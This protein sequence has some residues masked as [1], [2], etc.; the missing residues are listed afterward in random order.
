MSMSSSTQHVWMGKKTRLHNRQFSWTAQKRNSSNN[1]K[2][3]Y[4]Q[5]LGCE[6][7]AQDITFRGNQSSANALVP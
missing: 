5:E 4:G 7:L 3:N 6:N 2:A 1:D